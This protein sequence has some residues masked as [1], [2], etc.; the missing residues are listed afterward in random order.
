[1]NATLHQCGKS[2]SVMRDIS[3]AIGA[4]IT[5]PCPRGRGLLV[6]SK[7]PAGI[8]EFSHQNLDDVVGLYIGTNLYQLLSIAVFLIVIHMKALLDSRKN[9]VLFSK[10]RVGVC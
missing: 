5:D 8:S 3:D 1:M 9:V 2:A 7:V 6:S 10:R 4:G